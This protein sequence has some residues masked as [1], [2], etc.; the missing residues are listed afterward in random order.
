[1]YEIKRFSKITTQL[2]RICGVSQGTL[3]RT[4]HN[5]DG[6]NP[7]TR[8]RILKIAKE[9]DYHQ[10]VQVPGKANSMLIGVI[11]FDFY[12]EYFSKLD[13]SLGNAQRMRLNGFVRLWKRPTKAIVS[14]QMSKIFRNVAIVCAT[15]YYVIL[16]L[17]YLEYPT[18]ILIAGFDNVSKLKI[19]KQRGQRV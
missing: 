7:K 9:Y 16:A 11:L 12:N 5:R 1:M 6:I 8:D 15:D 19:D 2:A 10:I 13:M 18:D 3:D 14:S 17:K 4:L